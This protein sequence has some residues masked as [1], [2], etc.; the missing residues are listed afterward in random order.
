MSNPRVLVLTNMFPTEAHPAFG[1]FVADQV[2]SLRRL[3][4]DIDVLFL[5]PRETRLNYL[6]GPL[7]LRRQIHAKQYDL[8][9]AHYLFCGIIAVTQKQLPVVLTHHGIE[10]LTSWTAP[11]SRWFSR[12][13]DVTIV[14]SNEMADRLPMKTLVI[15]CGLDLDNFKPMPKHAARREL[16]L[17]T[18]KQLILFVGEPRREKRL[19]LIRRSV[20]T[21][22]NSN[23][24]VELVV[25][26]HQPHSQVPL[27]MNASDVLV[28]VSDHEGS[29][30]VVKE[31]MACG[32]PIVSTRV[33]DV[34]E[35][36]GNTEGCFLCRQDVADISARL[37]D[38]LAFGRRTDGRSRVEHF[39]LERI[40]ARILDT[41]NEARRPRP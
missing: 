16:G 23:N 13:V 28:L 27:W 41:Y 6:K 1:T 17:P 8:I 3:G 18:D 30:L 31:A 36:I 39:A 35:L 19:D 34:A 33:G 9:H 38:V 40:A 4:V 2:E 20:E 21:L 25:V 14:S 7:R 15:P 11:V 24:T 10:V 5:N 12:L 26:S 32:L 37:G 22:R 29:P